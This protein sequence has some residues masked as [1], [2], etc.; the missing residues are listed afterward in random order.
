MHFKRCFWKN[1]S[2]THREKKPHGQAEFPP[3]DRLVLIL[4]TFSA[5]ELVG[6]FQIIFQ[7]LWSFNES[8][9]PIARIT[10]SD[11]LAQRE[12]SRSAVPLN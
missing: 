5:A 7:V 11:I 12:T 1:A 4:S 10:L 6:L 8:L 3:I 9:K 2:G